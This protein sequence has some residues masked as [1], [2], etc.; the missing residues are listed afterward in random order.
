VVIQICLT[1]LRSNRYPRGRRFDSLASPFFL[2]APS[3][4]TGGGADGAAPEASVEGEAPS[5]LF[6]P[7]PLVQQKQRQTSEAWVL[8]FYSLLSPRKDARPLISFLPLPPRATKAKAD[9]RSLGAVLLLS[10]LPP[11]GCKA[12]HLF[13]TPSPS[14][15]KSKG[16][17]AKPGC[18]T[19]FSFSPR[20]DLKAPHLFFTPSPS[21]N[22]SKGRRAKPGVLKFFSLL[23]PA[24]MQG[25]SSHFFSFL[26]RGTKAADERS[27]G[28][29]LLFFFFFSPRKDARPLISFSPIPP[30]STE[31]K[32]DERSLGAVDLSPSPPARTQG[33]SSLF[34]PSPSGNKSKGRRAK[35]G[36]CRF[37]SFSPRKDA[38][39]LVFR[40]V[41]SCNT[42]PGRRVK[43][44]CLSFC[45]SLS[46]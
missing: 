25:P 1:G 40:I 11:Q 44:R 23:S 4:L 21:G 24:G 2:L 32:A 12:P 43:P 19:F 45:F 17:R 33:P 27:L 46:L 38:R 13:F 15:N 34:Y 8:Y 14:G 18:C 39:P 29:V 30:R 22:K 5:S 7:F 41:S 28:A 3:G 6:C 16:R 20:K 10:S 35:P 31:A 36:C 9:E 26:A 42:R 37:F